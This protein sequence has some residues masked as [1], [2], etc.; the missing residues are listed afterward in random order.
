MVTY[1]RFAPHLHAHL[2]EPNNL[3]LTGAL[4]KTRL[5]NDLFPV[6]VPMIDGTVTIDDIVDRVLEHR[7]DTDA[8]HVY[9]LLFK[10]VQ[11]GFLVEASRGTSQ[12][13]AFAHAIRSEGMAA[14]GLVSA[15]IPVAIVAVGTARA[16]AIKDVLLASGCHEDSQADTTIVVTDDLLQGE[17][18]VINLAHLASGKAWILVRPNGMDPLVGPRFV[19]GKTACWECLAE[20]QRHNRDLEVFLG[21]LTPDAFPFPE[22]VHV[23]GADYFL[24]GRLAAVLAAQT[25]H[26]SSPLDGAIQA[27]HG[28]DGSSTIHRVVQRPQCPACGSSTMVHEPSPVTL[29]SSPRRSATDAGYR[30]TTADDVYARYKHHVSHITGVVSTLERITDPSDPVQHVYISGQ[31]MATRYRTFDNLRRELRS[32]SCGKGTTDMQARV[33]ALCEA[34]ER[35]SGVF[36]GDEYRRSATR[37]SLGADAIEPNDIMLFS[38]RQFQERD[39]WNS[40]DHKF[41]I[42]PFPMDGD[43]ILEWSPVWSC[44]EQRTKWL[45]T[46]QLYYNYH[47][48]Y[49]EFYYIADSNGAST[50]ATREEAILQGFLELVERD[51]VA[52]W[53]YNRLKMPGLDLTTFDH[54]Y[55]RAMEHQQHELDRDL[56]VLDVTNDLG[57]PVFVAFSRQRNNARE[58]ITFAP[59]AHIDPTIALLRALTE[60]NQMMPG[61][62]PGTGGAEYAYDD[63]HAVAW[64]KS[65]TTTNQPYIVADT[66]RP[67]RSREIYTPPTTTDL[68]EDIAYARAIIEDRGLEFLVHDQTRPDIGMPVVKVI[69]PGLRHFWARFG[70]GR[71]YDVPVALGWTSQATAES[72]LNPIAMFI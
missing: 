52:T 13:D 26:G 25:V 7:P 34:I 69:V 45:P 60:L 42:V 41:S 29:Q 57:I 44:T 8:A 6:V 38:E 23:P 47:K 66:G 43:R 11:R 24:A 67:A 48:A 54:P 50:G 27:Y 65:A 22:R 10:L 33:S 18:A 3:V 56:W 63:P 9:S 36:R 53:W 4:V 1:P 14:S 16:D 51:A 21:S 5:S 28:V 62:A 46:G 37:T 40:A 64:W 31:N 49:D 71:L 72:D 17:L 58:N 2:V 20:R 15:S 68:L 35:Y 19:P 30:S 12:H 70:T 55:V 59:G 32:S 61:V 39:A